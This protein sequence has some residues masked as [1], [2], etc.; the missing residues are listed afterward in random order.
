[1]VLEI[2]AA[3]VTGAALFANKV[4]QLRGDL[5][6]A[7]VSIRRLTIQ[8]NSLGIVLALS[9]VSC[10]LLTYKVLK[11]GTAEGQPQAQ[12]GEPAPTAVLARVREPPAGYVPA[13]NPEC[14]SEL[15]C[16]CCLDHRKDTLLRPCNHL[17]VCWPCANAIL[18]TSPQCPLC[19]ENIS[20]MEF[21][22][23]D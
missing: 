13:S 11:Q 10:A 15:L 7:D 18:A 6:R 14:E 8:R 9:G 4:T 2:I 17:A 3:G 19:R 20:A 22:Y 21:V 12:P 23:V 5:D 1:M 16:S